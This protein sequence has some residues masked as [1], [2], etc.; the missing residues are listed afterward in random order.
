[1]TYKLKTQLLSI[2][3]LAAFGFQCTDK[4]TLEL[5]NTTISLVGNNLVSRMMDYS[6]FETELH[7]RFPENY[8]IVRNMSDP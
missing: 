6:T 7:L 8:L 5:E 1:M 4:K 2:A 3:F